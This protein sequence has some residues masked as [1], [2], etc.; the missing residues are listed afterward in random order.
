[1]RCSDCNEYINHGDETAS[2]PDGLV[3]ARCAKVGKAHGREVDLFSLLEDIGR[4][5]KRVQELEREVEHHHRNIDF[6]IGGS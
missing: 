1:M 5:K 3:H 2:G 4:L 6:R